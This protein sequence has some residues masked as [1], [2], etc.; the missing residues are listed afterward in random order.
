MKRPSL[1]ICRNLRKS[2]PSPGGPPAPRYVGYCTFSQFSVLH[3]LLA[4]VL[5]VL[6]GTNELRLVDEYFQK[7]KS[8]EN[9]GGYSFDS[10]TKK[11][12]PSVVELLLG[13]A[14]LPAQ[15]HPRE[16][17][18]KQQALL[19][20]MNAAALLRVKAELGK[21]RHKG[22]LTTDQ[23]QLLKTRAKHGVVTDE[24]LGLLGQACAL[25]CDGTSDEQEYTEDISNVISEI[26]PVSQTSSTAAAPAQASQAQSVPP[27]DTP[28]ATASRADRR[29]S[30]AMA[31][32][33]KGSPNIWNAFIRGQGGKPVSACCMLYSP[34]L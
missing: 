26:Q 28:A 18:V 25:R 12:Q 4:G 3:W 10:P 15:L 21:L 32:A 7:T 13:A 9:R 20:T 24:V 17:R 8:C 14:L 6:A 34:V 1:G 22:A 27:P 16:A 23:F 33:A 11:S 30:S 29:K 5:S 31:K 19:L 2:N